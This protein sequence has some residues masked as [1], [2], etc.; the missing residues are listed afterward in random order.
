MGHKEESDR[1]SE[2]RARNGDKKDGEWKQKEGCRQKNKS[3]ITTEKNSTWIFCRRGKGKKD[4]NEERKK[5]AAHSEKPEGHLAK[6][7]EKKGDE[8]LKDKE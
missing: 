3:G 1:Q 2:G 5:V 4:R 6:N 8:E 7:R